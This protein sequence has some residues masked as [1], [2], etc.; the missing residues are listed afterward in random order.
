MSKIYW[1]TYRIFVCSVKR[2]L[3]SFTFLGQL[4]NQIVPSCLSVASMASV[5]LTMELFALAKVLGRR[6]K[7]RVDQSP[8]QCSPQHTTSLSLLCGI[9]PLGPL[10]FLYCHT[11]HCHVAMATQSP[12]SIDV[13]KSIPQNTSYQFLLPTVWE[14]A[15][16]M[17]LLLNS[18]PLNQVQGITDYQ[19]HWKKT[20]YWG[21][22]WCLVLN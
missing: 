12:V 3:L 17:E 15:V 8:S 2:E 21:Q 22:I 14:R 4:E 18:A 7:S 13:G 16:S 6:E 10:S 9:T 1:Q 11:I 19:I 20:I 5:S